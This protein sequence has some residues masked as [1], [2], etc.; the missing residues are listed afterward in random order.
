M[1]KPKKLSEEERLTKMLEA[2]MKQDRMTD[3]EELPGWWDQSDEFGNRC[4]IMT[5]EQVLKRLNK[6]IRVQFGVSRDSI[7]LDTNFVSDYGAD[8]LDLVEMMLRLE[9]AFLVPIRDDDATKLATVGDVYEYIKYGLKLKLKRVKQ[10][11]RIKLQRKRL[12]R[13]EQGQAYTS[14]DMKNDFKKLEI[15]MDD[16]RDD[17][18]FKE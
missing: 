10:R 18:M 16:L 7:T 12:L 13:L 14:E 1:D 3:S 15:I 6:V 4:L 5:D 11:I 17:V 8:S 2:L 9:E